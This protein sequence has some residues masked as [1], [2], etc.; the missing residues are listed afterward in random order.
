MRGAL[1]LA[2]GLA[3]CTQPD[4]LLVDAEVG[5]V[6]SLLQASAQPELLTVEPVEAGRRIARAIAPARLRL[7]ALDGEWRK[8]DD[9]RRREVMRRTTLICR[10]EL[11]AF[12]RQVSRLSDRFRDPALAPSFRPALRAA[13][14][15]LVAMWPLEIFSRDAA[16]ELEEMLEEA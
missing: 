6:R 4:E 12:Y 10:D 5:F 13:L 3:G 1:L 11:R 7:A 9:A 2:L 16:H 14:G 15:D 8:L